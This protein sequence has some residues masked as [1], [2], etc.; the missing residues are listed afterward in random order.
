ML[1]KRRILD[2]TPGMFQG[3]RPGWTNGLRG[4]T[5]AADCGAAHLKRRL[6]LGS[7][8]SPKAASLWHVRAGRKCMAHI[9][10]ST[11]RRLARS[12][13]SAATKQRLWCGW[14]RTNACCWW[15][16]VLS[17]TMGAS[18]PRPDQVLIPATVGRVSCCTRLWRSALEALSWC[19]FDWRSWA[20]DAALGQRH[21]RPLE[22]KESRSSG[23]E[24]RALGAWRQPLPGT[25]LVYVA[26]REGDVHELL[27]QGR[28]QGVELLIRAVRNRK[29]TTGGK[30]REQSARWPMY[31]GGRRTLAVSARPHKPARLAAV[32]RRW[33]GYT[34]R[35]SDAPQGQE[36]SGWVGNASPTSSRLAIPPRPALRSRAE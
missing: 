20:R 3:R 23:E 4:E 33:G 25:E 17:L 35:P 18:V 6:Q 19:T 31:D 11:T 12:G 5:R 36:P 13:S 29:A 24:L 30:I 27:A 22:P 2:C 14:L 9:A 32:G 21:D 8:N 10:S 34:A 15:E 28:A 16:T 1:H 26:Y 7:V